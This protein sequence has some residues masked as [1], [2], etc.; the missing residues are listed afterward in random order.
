MKQGIYYIEVGKDKG[1]YT[2]KYS[3]VYRDQACILYNGLN[4]SY[5][6]KK[7]IQLLDSHNEIITLAKQLTQR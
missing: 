6:H 1:S 2:L 3:C 7:R 4:V 5:G